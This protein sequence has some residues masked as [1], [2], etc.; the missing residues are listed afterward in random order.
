MPNH[1]GGAWQLIWLAA[2]TFICLRV[3]AFEMLPAHSPD[4]LTCS[5]TLYV[6]AVWNSMVAP[7]ALRPLSSFSACSQHAP[8]RLQRTLASSCTLYLRALDSGITCMLK[9]A[10]SQCAPEGPCALLPARGSKRPICALSHSRLC[11]CRRT[12]APCSSLV[13]YAILLRFLI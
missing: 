12:Y 10:C 8:T 6:N 1:S 7:R 13:L 3:P 9:L 4:T 11:I 2:D 5:C